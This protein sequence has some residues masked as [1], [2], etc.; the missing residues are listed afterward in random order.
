MNKLNRTAKDFVP[1]LTRLETVV[2]WVYMPIH[3]FLLPILIGMFQTLY[4]SGEISDITAN[5]IYYAIGLVVIVIFFG[6]MLRREFDNLLDN[7][8]HCVYGLCAGWCVWYVLTILFQVILMLLDLE[9]ANPNNETI[10]AIAGK[11]FNKMM[12]IAVIG[13][14]L[15]EEPIFRGVIFQSLRKRGRALAYVVSITL[16]SLYHVW[17][18]ALVDMDP[19]ILLY[20]LQY[21][22]I[23]LAITWSYERSGSLWTPMIFHALNNYTSFMAIEMLQSM[24]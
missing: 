4:P 23:T 17:Q 19:L 14:P 22:P 18:Y 11:D 15:I 6:K 1:E 3:V 12:A 8:R 10:T 20:A 13:A 21:V 2:G 16:F 7:F 24:G 5:M 9:L